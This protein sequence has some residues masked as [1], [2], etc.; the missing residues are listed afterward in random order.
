MFHAARP[1]LVW[2]SDAARRATWYG[3]VETIATGPMCSVSMTELRSH[4]KRS[5]RAIAHTAGATGDTT[6]RHATLNDTGRNVTFWYLAGQR[7]SEASG[8]LQHYRCR[9]WEHAL[10][11]A[12]ARMDPGLK[13]DR[14]TRYVLRRVGYAVLVVWAA[15]TITFL[16]L[17]S[18]PSDPVALMLAGGAGGEVQSDVNDSA[19]AAL[20]AEYGFDQPLIVQYFVLL[21]R[22][23][24]GDF[25][26]SIQYG[27]SVA[28]VIGQYLPETL[29]LAALALLFSL[30]LGFSVAILANYTRS[31]ALRTALFSLPPLAASF[32]SF[33]VG[34]TLLQLFSFSLGWF[35]AVGNEGFGSLVL[36][37][38]ALAIPGAATYAQ[39][40]GRGLEKTLEA[41]FIEIVRAKGARRA[42][43][44]LLHAFRN[45]IIPTLTLV[46]LTIG[47]IFAGVVVT[48]TVFSRNG[49]GRLL[50]AAVNTQ[51][52]PVVQ[53]LV[54]LSA[55]AF[56]IVNL[57]VDLIYPLI[58]PRITRRA[59]A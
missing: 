43:V 18:L 56:A 11:S 53:A 23:V 19:R 7:G 40:L 44:H 48:E 30:A 47:G 51:D 27:Q 22:A 35:P 36:P 49:L 6:D 54:V 16:L 37:A 24:S 31:N 1:P 33:W 13:G 42:R 9:A 45:A 50:Q 38:I 8:R 26:T 14:M 59:A 15:Y 52:I 29:K 17:F 46:G 28:Q 41:P 3:S 5:V 55:F 25:G 2:S 4:D 12:R 10:G 32:P 21:W 57:A 58:D 34:L 39:V 20:E